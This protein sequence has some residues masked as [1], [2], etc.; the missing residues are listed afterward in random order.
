LIDMAGT[1][2]FR[3]TS[4]LRRSRSLRQTG[5]TLV[6]L[7]VALLVGLFVVIAAMSAAQTFGAVGRSQDGQGG[8]AVAAMAS[9][10]ALRYD[11]QMAGLGFFSDAT[12][13]CA[14]INAQAAGAVLANGAVFQ[15]A[16]VDRMPDGT[17][18]LEVI[19]G[20]SVNAGAGS[21]TLS[22]MTGPMGTVTVDAGSNLRAGEVVLMSSPLTGMPCTV[23][24][25]G[26]AAAQAG[27][28]TELRFETA[29]GF[30]PGS[31]AG[32]F[33]ALAPYPDASSIAALGELVWR[34]YAVRND[35][36]VMTDMLTGIEVTVAQG[37]AQL[38]AQY[39]LSADAASAG[40]AAWQDAAGNQPLGAGDLARMRAIRIGLV[41]V[42][43]QRERAQGGSCDATGTAP[44]LWAG[45]S[46]NVSGRPDWQCFRYRAYAAVIGLRNLQWGQRL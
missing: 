45:E 18:R 32:T 5:A 26:A 16:R 24:T 9:L 4:L 17:D 8:T 29:T 41:T 10:G 40:I 13:Q 36:L 28:R 2:A 19:F 43:T 22:P 21:R 11:L 1:Q 46:A 27:G 20:T 33:A 7:M 38:R 39:G 6:E 14:T 44:E 12:P 42:N 3:S 25:V 34:R 23:A 31:W 37:V 35:A 30:T 15:A